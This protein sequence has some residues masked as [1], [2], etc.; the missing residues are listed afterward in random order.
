MAYHSPGIYLMVTWDLNQPL[1]PHYF[2]IWFSIIRNTWDGRCE[3]SLITV[4]FIIELPL[5]LVGISEVQNIWEAMVGML[6]CTK[7]WFIPNCLAPALDFHGMP[8]WIVFLS[9][10]YCSVSSLNIIT[11][12]FLYKIIASPSLKFT[13]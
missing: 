1:N 6:G 8:A 4:R 5:N 9:T 10:E 2:S 3:V 11:D 13:S 12:F 7:K